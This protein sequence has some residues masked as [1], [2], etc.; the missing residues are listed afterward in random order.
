MTGRSNGDRCSD[1][2][3]SESLDDPHLCG[4]VPCRDFLDIVLS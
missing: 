3:C 2:A 4:F 1:F